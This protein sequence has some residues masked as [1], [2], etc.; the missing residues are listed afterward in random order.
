M[1]YFAVL[2]LIIS[3]VFFH[4][5]FRASMSFYLCS[6]QLLM[7]DKILHFLSTSQ[8]WIV[9]ILTFLA[10]LLGD[11]SVIFRYMWILIMMDAIFGVYVSFLKGKFFLSYLGRETL[12]KGFI[13]TGIFIA[14]LYTERIFAEDAVIC[15]RLASSCI[16]GCELW[17]ILG[18]IS[19]I[20]PSLPIVR[21]LRKYLSGEIA[22]K[23]GCKVS[24]VEDILNNK[25]YRHENNETST[26][27]DQE[28]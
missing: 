12:K 18:N 28:I 7:T 21:L 2:I 8:G 10:S 1:Y 9:T 27:H 4:V 13:Y 19:I 26:R 16:C 15:T 11:A 24:E 20:N 6:K 23:L 3:A 17:S 25:R 14:V 22:K 5:L